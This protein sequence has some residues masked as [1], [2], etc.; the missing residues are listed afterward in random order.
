M[1]VKAEFYT[2]SGKMFKSATFEYKNRV[3]VNGKPREFISRMT[4]TSAIIK[5]DVT[6]INYGKP[7]LKR[8]SD[9]VFNL[10]LLTR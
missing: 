7:V 1:G 9:A 4:I 8:V 10:N 3:A 2:V 6:T 5:S